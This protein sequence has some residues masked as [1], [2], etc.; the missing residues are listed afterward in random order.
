MRRLIACFL[1]FGALLFS[2]GCHRDKEVAPRWELICLDVGQGHCTLLRTS[3]GDVLVDAGS[4]TSQV[5]LC[6]R[7]KSL[8]VTRLKLMILTHPDED[9]IG[10]ADGI[11][12][13][14]EVDE[15]CTNG[16]TAET[17]SYARLIETAERKSVPIRAIRAME[18]FSMDGAYVSVLWSPEQGDVSSND[19]S[20]ALLIRCNNFGAL[21]MGDVSM[22]VERELIERYGD[23]HLR[24]DVLIVGHHGS[25]TSTCDELLETACPQYAV[26]SCGAGN[27]Y[28]HPDGRA[29]ARIEKHGAEILRTDLEGDLRFAIYENEYMLF[30]KGDK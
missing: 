29:L 22:N 13:Q 19:E 30:K 5:D 3:E 9:H 4:E 6:Q 20:L 8:G 17:D 10:G 16:A 12:E 14:F 28:G 18:G 24:S 25:N 1:C 27:A 7:L 15:I 2:F 26:I 21:I 11:L 23:T